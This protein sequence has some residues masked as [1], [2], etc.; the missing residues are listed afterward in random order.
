M[1]NRIAP[2][3]LLFT[4]VALLAFSDI[5]KRKTIKSRSDSNPVGPVYIVVDKSDYVLQVFDEIGWYA[6]YPVVFGSQSLEDKMM[7]GDRKTPEGNF[8]I[9]NKRRHEK[10]HKFILIDYPNKES[11]NKFKERKLQGQIPNTARIGGGIGIHGTWPDDN[12]V[13]DGYS[14]WTQGCISLKNEDI[15]E[16][17]EYLRVGTRI[18]IR[19]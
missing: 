3:V 7:E 16:L 6:T 15:D 13:V 2:G 4:L 9:I 5:G 10:W 8:R 12:I 17:Y 1:K 18:S 19:K 14:N 11:W